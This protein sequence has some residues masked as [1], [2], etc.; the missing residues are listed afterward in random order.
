MFSDQPLGDIGERKIIDEILRPRY[1]QSESYQFGDDCAFV[2]NVSELPD[3]RIVATT[4]PCPEPVASLLG[5]TDLYYRGWLLA[6]INLSDLAAAG[7][8]PLGLL[9]SLILKNETTVNQL[10]RLLDGIDACCAQCQTRVI[11]GNLKEGDK[12]DLTATA[13]GICDGGRWLS[14]TG[15]REGDLVVVIGDLGLFWAGVI[16]LRS[17]LDLHDMKAELLRNV[18]TPIPKVRIGVL[19]ARRELLTS[20]IDNSD[21]LYPSLL[22]L[23][24]VNNCQM[25]I[26]LDIAFNPAVLFVASALNIDAAR[27]VLG[28]GDWQLIGCC[29]GSRF[30]EL[31]NIAQE[32]ALPVTVIGEVKRGSGVI[33]EYGGRMDEIA[34]LDSQRFTRDSWFT[35]GLEAYIDRLIDG[36]LWNKDQ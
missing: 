23:A 34:P 25:H 35:A 13:I 30:E 15:C 10:L 32:N 5:F 18:L 28:W 36:P 11:G 9:T 24:S 22:Q 1:G 20:C 29:D 33:L 26:R 14:R 17:N 31:K 8:R 6:T 7:A 21:G 16:A 2:S 27:F 19:L 4:D 3:G 12:L